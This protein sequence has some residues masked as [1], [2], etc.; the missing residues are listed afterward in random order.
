MAVDQVSDRHRWLH[1]PA[2]PGLRGG[3]GDWTVDPPAGPG[4]PSWHLASDLQ[5]LFVTTPLINPELVTLPDSG[6]LPQ[7]PFGSGFAWFGDDRPAL[8]AGLTTR[9]GRHH[10]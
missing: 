8:T 9:T 4:A 3:N 5:N 10:R 2:D 6:A 1:R 7:T